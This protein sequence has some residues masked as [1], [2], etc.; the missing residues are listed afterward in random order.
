MF[1]R[2]WQNFKRLFAGIDG[3]SGA[4][5]DETPSV[6]V[7]EVVRK[8][9]PYAR[10]Y[11]KYLPIILVLAAAGPGI[12]A[13]I[14]WMYKVLVDDVLV[15]GNLD[16]LVWI[17]FAYLGLNV[18]QGIV[19][20]FDSVLS[21]WVGGSFI[22][23][24]RTGF[25]THLQGLSLG[26]FDR[27]QLGDTISRVTDDV[28]EIEELL[29]SGVVSAVSYGFQLIF[30]TGALFYLDWRLA[31][32]SLLVAPLFW[33]AARYFSKKIKAASREERRRAGS[34]TA[35]TEE[36]LSNV[37]LVQAYNRQD[38]ETAR[39]HRENLGSFRAQLAATRLSATFSPLVNLIELAGVL[40]VIS[41][42]AYGLTQGRI[43][44]G[45]LLVFI[46]Y[47]SMLYRPIRGLSGL[48]NS[49]YA[50]SAGAERIMELLD[51]KPAVHE[52]EDACEM[53][54][55]R[56]RI[57]FDRVSFRYDGA[58]RD[59]LSEVS[60]SVE[61]G[62]TLALV[63]ASGS[64][65][66]TAAKLLLR[67]QDPTSGAVRIDGEDLRGVTLKSLRE[68]VAVLLQEALVFDGTV[69]ENIA[70]GRPG[71]TA[72]EVVEAAKAADA[73]RFIERL[74]DGYDTVIGQKGRLLSGGQRQRVAIARAIIR[75]SPVLVL[76]EP[77]TGLDADSSEKVMAPMRRLMGRRTTVVISH[78]LLSVREVDE[79]VVL[80]E[81]TIAERGT[82]GSLLAADG[83]YAKLY[84][85]QEVRAME[86]GMSEELEKET[87]EMLQNIDTVGMPER[88]VFGPA[89][90]A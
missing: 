19:S 80:N 16:A 34:I 38:E 1:D 76:D 56:G 29:L 10:P 9:W 22:V 21:E 64:G 3:D 63:G 89:G 55:A 74:P 90:R 39:F 66:S 12:E 68:N 84:R 15:A 77:T 48:L 62:R 47:L 20:F 81:G 85:L 75:N 40:V 53:G 43:T 33:V 58:E 23:S 37:A 82:H 27:R 28:E 4:I 5:V 17:A 25:F 50:A 11:R 44:V 54:R 86:A 59:A 83:V 88:T 36:S 70:Y 61:P 24:L 78:N 73:E 72:E 18:A 46:V 13:A 32:V 42:G 69:R 2:F 52:P 31:L 79:I 45:G 87:G 57:E 26:F 71:A 49:F 30:F 6:P 41:Y 7:R 14:V 67:F 65:K 35:V 60:F 8:F 51:E